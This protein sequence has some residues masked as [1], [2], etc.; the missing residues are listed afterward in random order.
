MLI[1]I[2][3]VGKRW[4]RTL[5]T[6]VSVCLVCVPLAAQQPRSAAPSDTAHL[7]TA[8]S[9]TTITPRVS[10]PLRLQRIGDKACNDQ[11]IMLIARRGNDAVRDVTWDMASSRGLEVS[12]SDSVAVVRRVALS[13]DSLNAVADSVIV[14]AIADAGASSQVQR[15]SALVRRGQQFCSP[16]FGGEIIRLTLGYEQVGASGTNGDQKFNFDLFINRPLPL[17]DWFEPVARWNEPDSSRN[18]F[19]GSPLR[20]F[21]DIRIASYPQPA[22]SAGA[23]FA[24]AF[25][26]N[27]GNVTLNKLVQTAEFTTGAEVRIAQFTASALSIPQFSE[28]RFALTVFGGFGAVGPFSPPSDVPVVYLVPDVTTPQGQAFHTTYDSVKSKYVAFRQ[29]TPDR[30]LVHRG[31]GIRLY[32]YYTDSGVPLPTPPAM[33]SIEYGLNRLINP[34]GRRARALHVSA[35]YPFTTGDRKDP[36]N[37]VFYLFG[38]V[39]MARGRPQYSGQAYE[40]SPALDASN[41]AVALSDPGVTIVTTTPMPR[42]TY[43]IGVSIDLLKVW[44]RLTAQPAT[45]TSGATPSTTTSSGSK[46]STSAPTTK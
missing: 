14:T 8:H 18:H 29:D 32:T 16:P 43:R 3:T 46:T 25:T 45:P 26:T 6:A 31:F 36:N 40:L 37:L 15:A 28:A 24:N 38:D 2:P 19:F 13:N 9:A 1:P 12:A 5:S 4:M 22:S 33:V 7:D 41:K 17:P 34:T 23:A 10:P 42:D 35:Y 20:W 11:P 44:K 30:F 39:W 21:G 27:A